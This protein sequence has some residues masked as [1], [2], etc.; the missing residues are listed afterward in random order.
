MQV[1]SVAAGQQWA[2]ALHGGAGGR[3]EELAVQGPGDYEKGLSDAYAAGAALLAVG[4]PAL[5]AVCAAVTSLEDNPLFNAGRGAALTR[6]GTIEHDAAVMTGDG[7][8]GAVTISR[9]ARNPVLAARR[10]R[11]DQQC[12][13]YS[14]VSRETLTGWG[15]E[16]VDQDYFVTPGRQAQLL[17]VQSSGVPGPQHGTVGAVALDR[18]GEVAAATS[19]GGTVNQVV[20]RIGDSPIIGAGTYARNGAAAVSCTGYG[21]AF[22][23]GVVAHEIVAR[24]RH[25]GQ[26]LTEAVA[27]VLETE[28]G[29]R[30]ATGGVIV[31]GADGQVVVAHNSPAMYAAFCRDE[32]VL[33][34]G[35]AGSVG[36]R[37]SALPAEASRASLG[38]PA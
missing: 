14:G 10:V 21:E 38:F 17:N 7:R 4:A 28:V 19:T 20:G 1:Y 3:I 24:V 31:V 6:A 23:Q 15:L 13:L 30:G 11:E 22:M 27:E 12:V 26:P 35:A 25:R 16:C 18:R 8:A 32:L 5:D 2:L 34:T 37:L 36:R 9:W 33:L 29:G